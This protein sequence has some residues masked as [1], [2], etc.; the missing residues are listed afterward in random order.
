M[1]PSAYLSKLQSWRIEIPSIHIV[2]GSGFGRALDSLDAM[3]WT[4]RGQLKFAEV[5]DLAQSTVQDHP[6]IFRFFS[7]SKTGKTI[8]FQVGRLH[9]YEGHPAPSVVKPVMIARQA[10]VENFIL[11]NSSGGLDRN[12]APGDVMLISD[13]VN[14]TGQNPLIGSNDDTL[15]PRFPD[16]G[17]LYV[18]EWREKLRIILIE[19]QLRVHEGVYLGLLG[20]SFET[21]AE[22]QLFANWG[23]K[24]V[25]MST[26]WEAIALKHSGARVAGLSLISNLGAGLSS[27]PLD[28]NA[29]LQTG[30]TTAVKILSA[31]C[32]FCEREFS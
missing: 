26:V 7:N 17:N 30:R 22:V 15:G 10:G 9:G 28:H 31:I 16:M 4:E 2:L 13:H 19:K 24:A 3:V 20:P 11:T 14:L 18:R 29:I 25:G 27:T 12:M 5:C 23:L 21:H 8:C 6:G 1:V 32:S